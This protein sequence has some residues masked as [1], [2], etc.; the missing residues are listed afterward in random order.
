MADGFDQ[1]EFIGDDGELSPSEH[2]ESIHTPSLSYTH[3]E[4]SL[5]SLEAGLDKFDEEKQDEAE[6]YANVTVFREVMQYIEEFGIYFYSRLDPDVDFVEAITGT[7]PKQVKENFEAIRDGKLDRIIEEYQDVDADEWLKQ[8]LGYDKIEESTDEVSLEDIV[9]KENELS[10]EIDNIDEAITVSLETIKTHLREIAEFF[11]RFEEPYN[12]IKHGN[13]VTPLTNHSFTV[14]G[15]DGEIEVEIDEKYVSFLCKTTGSRRG[16][17]LYTFT[18]PVRTLREQATAIVKLTRNIYTQIYDIRQKVKESQRTG[19]KVNLDPNFYGISNSSGGGSQFSLKSIENPDATIWLPEEVLSESIDQYEL[20][21]SGEVAVGIYEQG[22]EMV[23]KTEGDHSPSYEYPLLVDAEMQGD[24]D[25]LQG[26]KITQD[27]SFKLYELPLWQY[28]EF[29]SLSEIEP[30]QSVTLEFVS[31][32]ESETRHTDTP[33]SL[34]SLPEPE[35][36]DLLQF[37]RNVGR[38]A[39]AEIWVPYYWP[40]RIPQVV[41]YYRQERDLTRDVAKELLDG[42]SELTDETVVTIPTISILN[43]DSIDDEG[44]YQSIEHEELQLKMG[45]IILEVDEKWGEGEFSLVSGDDSRYKRNEVGHV[46]GIGVTFT[47]EN[48]ESVYQEFVQKGLDAVTELSITNNPDQ[49]ESIL[50]TKRVYGP[51]FTWYHLDEFHF[52]LYNEIPPHIDIEPE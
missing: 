12:A 3:I 25:H 14:E 7:R 50:E 29:L 34:P 47:E 8:E 20:P 44:N 42:I 33:I 24:S 16:G 30:V 11:L 4:K 48:P 26:I 40:V 52:A 21:I 6:I 10:S 13:R 51:K 32:G 38:A 36:P 39:D 18:V 2:F 17:E 15:P 41:E 31:T 37:M 27:F 23:V 5:A 28:L 22:G 9:D 35:F 45:G 46:E 49:A 43:P 1:S 19:E